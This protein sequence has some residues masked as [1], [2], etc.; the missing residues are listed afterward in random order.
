MMKSRNSSR[1]LRASSCAF[2]RSV[3]CFSLGL[4][5]SCH[6]AP[7]AVLT[8]PT[9]S[10]TRATTCSPVNCGIRHPEPEAVHGS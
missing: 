10:V 2:S 6:T 7:A 1:D 8:A 4:T 9:R 3:S 5:K